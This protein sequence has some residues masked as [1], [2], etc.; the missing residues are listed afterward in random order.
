MTKPFAVAIDGPVAAGKTT[1]GRM[2]ASRISALFFDTGLLYRA[3]A[4]QVLARGIDPEDRAAVAELTSSMN[5][6]LNE[7]GGETRLIIEGQDISNDLR[8]PE[9]D[10]TLPSVSA[11]PEVRRALLSLQRDIVRGRRAVVVGRDIG[12]VVLSDAD[13]KIYLAARRDVR[14]TR[15]YEEMRERGVEI[16]WDTVY[17]DLLARDERDSSRKHAP[18]MK[19]DDAVA[20]DASTRDVPEVV[21]VIANLVGDRGGLCQP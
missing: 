9:I 1:V 21:E 17:Q 3:V 5:V 12:T 11:N 16:D 4:H 2:L 15:R 18:L 14:A 6:D 10:R 8:S 20:V 7:S 19:A 13:L